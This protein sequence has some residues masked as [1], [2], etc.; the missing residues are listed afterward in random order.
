MF[1]GRT[2]AHVKSNSGLFLSLESLEADLEKQF[3]S[4]TFAFQSLHDQTIRAVVLSPTTSR[5]FVLPPPL[6]QK[7][8]TFVPNDNWSVETGLLTPSLKKNRP[9]LQQRYDAPP[10]AAAG[11]GDSSTF[12]DLRTYVQ[13]GDIEGIG[14]VLTGGDDSRRLDLTK[15]FAE[16]GL[17]S[18]QM[19]QV[20]H[21]IGRRLPLPFLFHRPLHEVQRALLDPEYCCKASQVAARV[22][23]EL[24]ALMLEDC[25]LPILTLSAPGDRVA[26]ATDAV[27]TSSVD[28]GDRT[29]ILLTGATGFIGIHVLRELL[30]SHPT[31]S[32]WCL[33]RAAN[34]EEGLRRVQRTAQDF[35]VSDIP[36]E[37]WSRVHA[38]CG[39]LGAVVVPSATDVQ[40]LQRHVGV[41]VHLAATVNWRSRYQDLRVA[42]VLGTRWLLSLAASVQPPM[43]LV[44]ASTIGVLTKALRATNQLHLAFWRDLEAPVDT[45]QVGEAISE[46]ADIGTDVT[47]AG[48]LDDNGYSQTKWVCDRLLLGHAESVPSTLCRIAFVGW[49]GRTGAANRTDF[50]ARFVRS[51]HRQQAA[52]ASDDA[53]SAINLLPVEA[54]AVRLAAAATA[55]G[56]V[57]QVLNFTN[58]HATGDLL[59]ARLARA[60]SDRVEFV[61]HADFVERV[62][63]DPKD[64]MLPLLPTIVHRLPRPWHLDDSAM[65]KLVK[66]D[67]IDAITDDSIN[68]FIHWIL[69]ADR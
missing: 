54:A 24:A 58:N 60:V 31:R 61:Q 18:I 43:R 50:F 63:K 21:V 15:S 39:E 3:Q 12:Q 62:A 19:A 49:C 37:S 36:Q 9:A 25:R 64:P 48:V 30:V 41:I 8:V 4:P 16:N 28:G 66:T 22:D 69:R 67:Q 23:P 38:V 27:P 17:T 26:A 6:E 52:P 44:H 59:F 35:Q 10:A 2:S 68:R 7:D 34:A 42:N 57:P 47:E 32:V 65:Q 51:V 1:L 11:K 53:L 56:P 46:D 29:G 40:L 14:R 45:K 33:V 13:Q 55:N 20:A 5:K